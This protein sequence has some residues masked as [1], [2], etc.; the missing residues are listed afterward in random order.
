MADTISVQLSAQDAQFIAS[1]KAASSAMAALAAQEARLAKVAKASGVDQKKF[2]AQFAQVER[3]RTADA[4]RAVSDD[5]KKTADAAKK[6]IADQKKRDDQQ[7]KANAYAVKSAAESKKNLADDVSG[8][9]AGGAAAVG[10]GLA[11]VGI[12][13]AGGLALA[14]IA[15][16]GLA[17]G[18]AKEE[19]LGALDILT[20]GRGDKALALIDKEA[21]QLGLSIQATRDDFIKFRQA[22]LDNGQSAALLKLKAD[23][24]AT[25]RPAQ[26]V[27]E[28]VD[29]VLSYTSNGTQTAAQIDASTRAMKLLAKQAHVSGTGIEAAAY[30][31][32]SLDS[33]VNRI[34]NTKTKLLEGIG[35]KI[36]PSVDKAATAVADLVD[37]LVSSDAGKKAIAGVGDAIVLMANAVADA[38]P[39]VEA[40]AA[41][42]SDKLSSPTGK[43]ALDALKGVA[44]LAAGAIA[45]LAAGAALV[46]AP[47][48]AIGAAGVAA[49][50][51]LGLL[52]TKAIQLGPAMYD[53]AGQVVSGFVSGIT[54]KASA[55]YQSVK[56]LASGIS[57]AFTHALGIHSPSRVFELHAG[58][59]DKGA[60]R[61]IERNAK[62]PIGAARDMADDVSQAFAPDRATP[63]GQQSP[64]FAPQNAPAP[65]DAGGDRSISITIE[66]IT[67]PH[68]ADPDAFMR[69]ARREFTLAAQAILLSQGLPAGSPA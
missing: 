43:L 4:A 31:A 62:G 5:K 24:I 33:A 26:Q 57:K 47:I 2:S 66:N 53:A 37:R 41:A 51:G 68:G 13:T 27:Q 69:S 45:V 55:A 7:K 49:I 52:V 34:D 21:V 9:L 38:A 8:L 35:E 39:K 59:V 15:K 23:L 58:N 64:I 30:A 60:E 18:R 10:M 50:A 17:M 48:A 29:R 44:I 28:A 67:V 3:K 12:A 6:K 14:A 42:I 11:I 19:T 46:V 63:T 25:H 61:G 20:N 16:L 56:N 32:T 22:G 1:T 65:A 36:K 54:D 40:F